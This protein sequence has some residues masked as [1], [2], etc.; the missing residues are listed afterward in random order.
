MSVNI[1]TA[2]GLKRIS[3]DNLT[4][5]KVISA[6]GY[7]PANEEDLKNYATL[8]DLSGYLPKEDD[9]D[10]FSIADPSGNIIFQ[11]NQNGVNSVDYLIKGK[12]ILTTIQ[13]SVF[14][15]D[16]NDLT[17]KPIESTGEDTDFAISDKNGNLIIKIDA[18]GVNAA[19]YMIKGVNLYDIFTDENY[20]DQSVDGLRSEIEQNYTTYDYVDNAVSN[21][22]GSI[23]L[24]ASNI[25][26]EDNVGYGTDN[27]QD[28]LDLIFGHNHD[29][30]YLK[31][32]DAAS[33]Y[34]TKTSLND[35]L[36][37]VDAEATYLPQIDEGDSFTITDEDGN[38]AFQVDQNGVNSVNYFVKGVNISDIYLSKD[39]AAS[40]YAVAS[41]NHDDIYSK[42]GHT[43]NYTD[44]AYVDQK[45]DDLQSYIEQN[46]PTTADMNSA[47]SS[48]IA[49]GSVTAGDI[50]YDDPGYGAATVQEA[51]DAIYGHH[52]D[53]A[54]SK[55]GHNHDSEYSKVDH[56]HDSVYLKITD[57]SSTYFTKDE[58]SSN[59]AALQQNIAG[60]YATQASLSDYLKSTD[61][62]STYLKKAD[63]KTY[64]LPQATSDA[65]GGVKIGYEDNGKAYG[66]KLDTNGKMYVHVPWTEYTLPEATSSVLGGVKMD[67]TG[68]CL[69]QAD[70]KIVPDAAS[71]VAYIEQQGF[72]PKEDEGDN[73]T[74][75]DET[76]NII[77]TVDKN[78]VNSVDYLIKGESIINIINAKIAEAVTGGEVDLS[79]YLTVADASS[80]YATKAALTNY[81]TQSYVST[82]YATKD[83]ISDMLTKTDAAATYFTI[84]DWQSNSSALQQNIAGTYATISSLSDYLKSTD[85]SSTYLKK[86]D[87]ASTYLKIADKYVLPE[88]TA[89]TLGGVMID[90]TV[91]GID[92]AQEL[93]TS[94]P[95]VY[96]V[97]Q[98]FS[99]NRDAALAT[100]AANYAAKDHT[101][102][103]Y[104]TEDWL[105]DEQD[106]DQSKTDLLPT[107][108]AVNEWVTGKGYI[109]SS[110]LSPYLKSTDAA[111]TYALATHDH[112]SVYL[113]KTDAASTYATA[114]TVSG[115]QNDVSNIEQAIDQINEAGYI[116]SSALS[117][118][119]KSTDASSTYATKSL[120]Q[121][122]DEKCADTY[123]PL[124]GGDLTG[125]VS[126]D[127]NE[128]IECDKGSGNG[129]FNAGGYPGISTDDRS[130]YISGGQF[131]TEQGY[132]VY[133]PLGP[134]TLASTDDT[135]YQHDIYIMPAASPL[136]GVY[137]YLTLNVKGKSTTFA[138]V[139]E[140]AAELYARGN[141]SQYYAVQATGRYG[142]S[143]SNFTGIVVGVFATSA[144]NLTIMTLN[145]TN[146]AITLNSNDASAFTSMRDLV[147]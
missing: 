40:M 112:D 20:V 118:Y 59:Y 62:A 36:T 58:W 24:N 11:V 17:N 100:V 125:T 109:T 60:T 136:G 116:T 129:F 122:L 18:A 75:T 135:S 91:Q 133:F 139:S 9:G 26:Y 46:Y 54:Y 77:F 43:H 114:A 50:T 51:L 27:V 104:L 130:I 69:D 121:D 124:S 126:I 134:C 41:H 8:V 3:G 72:L 4:S 80:T 132:W 90:T 65:L 67:T 1:Q 141:V 49:G 146:G 106:I 78:G 16:Y 64:T 42:L 39:D 115:L 81:A 84:S 13:E 87:A 10:S 53:D 138:N 57:A 45:V 107:C 96:A 30:V 32:T 19:A 99:T 21:A 83:S 140:V 120:V 147:N 76:G 131:N 94:V 71:I 127:Q 145:P 14:S 142:S 74:L 2:N 128:G 119:L 63:Y 47:I 89:N 113:K 98:Y 92:G 103:E 144:T 25:S 123:L 29:S 108:A 48:A 31:I 79:A 23:S 68:Q 70:V 66:V 137:V 97:Q 102:D 34:A 82:G 111:S 52:H 61:A 6:L 95:T 37:I 93:D 15:G 44:E 117:P 12:S 85:A 38:I 110:A 101:H 73:F 88:A 33:T 22:V 56:N 105:G 55:L 35:Y 86:T 7:T 28:T 143:S 5:T